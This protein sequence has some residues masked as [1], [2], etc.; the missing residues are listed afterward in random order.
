M[1][2]KDKMDVLSIHLCTYID[3]THYHHFLHV[4]MIYLHAHKMGACVQC[5]MNIKKITKYTICEKKDCSP[6]Y[7]H[8]G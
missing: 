1:N 4:C 7:L 8:N 3:C 6:Y 2:K 5:K